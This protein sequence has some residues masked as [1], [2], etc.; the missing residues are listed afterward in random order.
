MAHPSMFRRI[1]FRWMETQ[2]DIKEYGWS[3]GYGRSLSEDG[4]ELT[5]YIKTPVHAYSISAQQIKKM[6]FNVVK[7]LN[8]FNCL[9]K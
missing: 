1:G 6:D 5:E 2:P 8:H 9:K 4:K 7:V 3:K